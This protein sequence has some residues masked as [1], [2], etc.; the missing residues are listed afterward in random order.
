MSQFID[1]SIKKKK[2]RETNDI[3]INNI[4]KFCE[5]QQC[6]K[7]NTCMRGFFIYFV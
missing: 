5:F 4:S 2:K 3:S 7:L 1:F 6:S